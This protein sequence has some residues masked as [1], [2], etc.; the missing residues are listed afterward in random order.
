MQ[1]RKKNE[2]GITKLETG[3]ARCLVPIPISYERAR[4]FHRHTK[5]HPR[6]IEAQTQTQRRRVRDGRSKKFR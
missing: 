3:R 6:I 4:S 2:I 5:R 1:R